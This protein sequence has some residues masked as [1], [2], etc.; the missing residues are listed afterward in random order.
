MTEEEV[1]CTGKTRFYTRAAAR[2]RSRQIRRTGGPR[3]RPY[4]CSYCGCHHLG[5][6]PGQATYLR[7]GQPLEPTT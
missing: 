3:L 4:H 7:K 5:H 2:T 1:S 6:E